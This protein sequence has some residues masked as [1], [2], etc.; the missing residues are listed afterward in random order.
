M[1]IYYF[2]I[3]CNVYYYK[4]TR[5]NNYPEMSFCLQW[6]NNEEGFA[7]SLQ[8]SKHFKKGSAEYCNSRGEKHFPNLRAHAHYWRRCVSKRRAKI[9][10][11]V[12]RSPKR[13]LNLRAMR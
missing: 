6:A 11:A 13:N 5:K 3:H 2:L 12:S 8:N 1:H 7:H 10:A 4:R 9:S